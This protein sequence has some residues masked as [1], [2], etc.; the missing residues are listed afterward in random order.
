[1]T[2]DDDGDKNTRPNFLKKATV[3]TGNHYKN[4]N[5]AMS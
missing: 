4:R 3:L 2:Q 1:M 5:R